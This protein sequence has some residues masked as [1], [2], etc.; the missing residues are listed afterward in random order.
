M[1]F[2][3]LKLKQRIKELNAEPEETRGPAWNGQIR[4]AEA[5]LNENEKFL[6]AYDALQKIPG[7][8]ELTDQWWKGDAKTRKEVEPKIEQLL[9]Q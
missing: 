6:K 4:F 3:F 2:L 9:S 8:F 1:N 5:R 7:Y